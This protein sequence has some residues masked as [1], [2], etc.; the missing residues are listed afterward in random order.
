MNTDKWK[1]SQKYPAELQTVEDRRIE[2]D[3][4]AKGYSLTQEREL[5]LCLEDWVTKWLHCSWS[6]SI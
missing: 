3:K 6:I 5:E 1:K 4:A 2:K